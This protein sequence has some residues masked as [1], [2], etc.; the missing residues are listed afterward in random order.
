MYDLQPRQSTALQAEPANTSITA[1]VN[2]F[3][4]LAMDH[5]LQFMRNDAQYAEIKEF[6]DMCKVVLDIEASTKDTKPE[7]TINIAIQNI[8]G[9]FKD[10]C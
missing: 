1:D 8:L 7:S 10:D 3:K 5:A 6:K 2:E 4:S 9:G